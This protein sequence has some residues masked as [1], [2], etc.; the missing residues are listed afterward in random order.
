MNDISNDEDVNVKIHYIKL[1]FSYVEIFGAKANL[2]E[3]VQKLV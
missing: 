3:V 2:K 1:L